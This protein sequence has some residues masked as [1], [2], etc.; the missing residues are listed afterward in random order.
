[1]RDPVAHINGAALSPIVQAAL[2]HAQFETIHPF[3]DGNG[4]VGRAL[5]H[6]VLTRRGLTEQA[7]LP[8]SLVLATLSRE[9]VAGLTAYRH[10]DRPGSDAAIGAIDEWLTIFV[11]AT[12]VAVDQSELLAAQIT[13]LRALWEERLATHRIAQGLRAT[14]RA[15]STT[16][17]LLA[18]LPEA[19][20]T[21]ARTLERILDISYP[22]ASSA[23][24][25]LKSAGILLTRSI[26]RGTQAYIAREILDLVTYSEK[27]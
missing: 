20:V 21:T 15:N 22:A 23:L 2:V 24:E 12:E 1:M 3:T 19:P 7:V 5:I 16:S 9:Y 25:E 26:E 8:I 17:W 18:N 27:V 4:R 10:G 6:T 11:A 13:D 14:P